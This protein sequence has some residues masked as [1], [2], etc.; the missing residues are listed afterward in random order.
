MENIKIPEGYQQVMTYLI[1]QGA[2][3]F[4]RFAEKIFGA[5]EIRK[6]MRD[7]NTIMH[8]EIIIGDTTIMIADSTE[9]FKPSPAGF[10]IYVK[11]ADHTYAKAIGEGAKKV[12]EVDD[13]T[14][15]RSGGI[16]DPFGNT[17]WITSVK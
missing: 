5:K 3:N 13:Q 15:G 1:V 4:I 10:F 6:V 12:M 14:Y 2:E 8:A 7:E 9:A 17:W 11:N 16:E